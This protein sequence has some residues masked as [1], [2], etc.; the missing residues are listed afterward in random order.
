MPGRK[1]CLVAKLFRDTTSTGKTPQVQCLFCEE[2]IVKND[3]RMTKH[4][5][6]CL[7]CD[8]SVKLKY[9]TPAKNKDVQQESQACSAMDA[10]DSNNL[11]HLPEQSRK[12]A[13]KSPSGSRQTKVT[14]Y[15]TTP[16]SESTLATST[17][18]KSKTPSFIASQE[19]KINRY[20]DS[21]NEN[22]IVSNYFL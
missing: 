7:K 3:S 2:K 5:A 4:I 12:E 14:S 15:L 22:Q 1:K 9:L 16:V 19:N 13:R 20:V 10:D 18:T 11:R 8:E 6:K 17:S 21:M